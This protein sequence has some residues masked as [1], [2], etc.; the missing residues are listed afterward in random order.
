MMLN[1]HVV[2]RGWL[3]CAVVGLLA[4]AGCSGGADFGE[5]ITVPQERHTKIDEAFGAGKTLRLPADMPFNVTDAQRFSQGGA[6]AESSADA[7]GKARCSASAQAGGSAWAE[8]QLG[9][10]LTC[11]GDTPFEA[12]VTFNVTYR[13]RMES[14]GAAGTVTPDKFALKAY[15]MDSNRRMLKRMML[16]E[17]EPA[18]GPT[19]WSGTQS[20]AFDVTFEPGLAYHLVL[21]G[22]AEVS[23]D[24][25]RSPSAEIQVESLELEITPRR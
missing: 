1:M 18:K 16:A 13:Y 11:A 22:R 14:E 17:L 3:G 24:E 25:D 15:I 2:V 8:M 7:S 23:G 5:S 19:T 12:T 10:V 20:P 4:A 6:V 21:A 9:H